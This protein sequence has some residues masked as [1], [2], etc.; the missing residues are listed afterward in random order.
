M[1]LELTELALELI[2]LALELLELVLELPE[3]G[4]EPPEVGLELPEL[5]L[6]LVLEELAVAGGRALVIAGAS[7]SKGRNDQAPH[8]SNSRTCVWYFL[9]KIMNLADFVNN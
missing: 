6:E 7:L 4:L 5:G 1:A 2:E 8:P 3:L 9:Q